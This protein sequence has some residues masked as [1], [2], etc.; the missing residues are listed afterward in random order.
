MTALG[1]WIVCLE[2]SNHF[3]H[4]EIKGLNNEA[5]GAKGGSDRC[6]KAGRQQKSQRDALPEATQWKALCPPSRN[7]EGQQFDR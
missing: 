6:W 4:L 3:C 7:K 1:V 2:S 5:G